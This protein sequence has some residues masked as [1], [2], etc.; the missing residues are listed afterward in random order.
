MRSVVVTIPGIKGWA[1]DRLY[2]PLNSL[3]GVSVLYTDRDTFGDWPQDGLLHM[4]YFGHL[5]NSHVQPERVILSVHHLEPAHEKRIVTICASGR[6]AGVT[7]SYPGS[8][9]ALARADAPVRFIP[10]WVEPCVSMGRTRDTV[11]LLGMRWSLKRHEAIKAAA[12]IAGV[13]VVD[14]TRDPADV[15]I[16]TLHLDDFYDGIGCYVNAAYCDAGPLPA[17]DALARGIPVVTTPEGS[18]PMYLQN[19]VNGY[20][21]DGSVVDMARKIEMALDLPDFAPPRMP[22]RQEWLDAHA[23]MYDAAQA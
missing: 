11:G 7:A 2:A 13:N 9:A 4:T 23:E 17:L 10:Y 22:T 14:C 3:D 6:L 18:V 21:T 5:T 15:S 19:G 12:A 16:P 20:Y 1:L 8:F